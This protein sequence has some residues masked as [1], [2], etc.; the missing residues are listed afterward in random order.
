MCQVSILR[1]NWFTVV[2]ILSYFWLRCTHNMKS[3]TAFIHKCN[4]HGKLLHILQQFKTMNSQTLIIQDTFLGF[5]VADN[6]IQQP[7]TH[8][9]F[10]HFIANKTHSTNNSIMF[11][12]S[13]STQPVT[14]HSN[15]RHSCFE[16]HYY[17]IISNDND[18]K[19]NAIWHKT[20]SIIFNS[21]LGSSIFHWVSFVHVFINTTFHA[22]YQ[23]TSRTSPGLKA[24]LV[25]YV[26]S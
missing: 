13:D 17:C 11:Q 3:I 5:P 21:I 12:G 1:S 24:Q 26:S 4:I 18:E 2:L 9:H 19:G 23:Y 25:S 20:D 7:V 6:S 10:S 8:V 14:V 15:N 22:V 16:L